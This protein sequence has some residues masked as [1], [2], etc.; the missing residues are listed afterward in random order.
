MKKRLIEAPEDY[1]PSEALLKWAEK[2]EYWK[3]N[4]ETLAEECLD[5]HRARGNQF[6]SWD[7]V[8]RTWCRNDKKFYPEKYKGDIFTPADVAAF[9][10]HQKRYEE[11]KR[12]V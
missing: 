9:E 8:V 12:G 5:H 1:K 4:L 7:A 2:E 3:V 6:V 10:K 11:S